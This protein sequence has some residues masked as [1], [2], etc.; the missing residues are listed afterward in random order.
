VPNNVKAPED[1]KA[2]STAAAK[3]EATGEAQPMSF[4]FDGETY[5]I[6]A[7]AADDLELMEYI[8]SEKYILALKGY[9]GAEQW[10]RFKDTHR[11][12]KGRVT[13]SRAGDFLQALTEA[14]GAGNS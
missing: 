10:N 1:H 5:T 12:D 4:E 8:E 6:D 14:I 9:L 11:N 7:D 3:A 2:K 13:A